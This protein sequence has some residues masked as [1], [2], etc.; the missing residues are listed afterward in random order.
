MNLLILDS[1]DNKTFGGYQNWICLIAPEL[2]ERGHKITIVSRP[3]SEFYNRFKKHPELMSIF[4]LAISG[5]FNPFTISKLTKLFNNENIDIVICD[6]NKDV[7]LGG[8]AAIFSNRPKVIWH[9]GLNITKNNFVHRFLT[10]RLIDTAVVPSVDLKK[11]VVAAGYIDDKIVTVIPHGIPEPDFDL[12]D[13][14]AGEILRDKYNI[15]KENIIAVT[16]GRF[17]S[18]KGHKYLVEA[19]REITEKYPTITF[20]LLGNGPLESK[21][22]AKIA[23][24]NLDKH[25]VFAGMLSNFN[26]ELAGSDLM[27]HPS[28]EEP[29][30]FSVLEGMRAGLPVVA[31]KIGGIPEFAVNN[32]TALLIEP[33]NGKLI[34]KAVLEF[35]NSPEKLKDFGKAGKQRWFS[36]FRLDVMVDA[37]EKYFDNLI[38]SEN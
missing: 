16:S 14:E 21:L 8:L 25:F 5:D 26:L 37:W 22:K 23:E 9:L 2:A 3:K 13:N 33:K 27:I 29:F 30:G 28:V 34:S 12:S 24:Y 38:N 19:A 15:P 17:V 7:R 6:F 20:L 18:Q 31:S 4:E 36:D 32:K 35:L 11:Q 1:I 10:P